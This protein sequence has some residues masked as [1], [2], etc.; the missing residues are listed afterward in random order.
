MAVCQDLM[1]KSS[2]G[3]GTGERGGSTTLRDIAATAGVGVATVSRVLNKSPLV[4]P[5]T[6]ERV[7]R[8]M[9]ELGYQ[10]RPPE[11]R[12]GRAKKRSRELGPQAVCIVL[13]G[14]HTLQWVTNCAPV[15]AYALNGA[16]STLN[17]HGINCLLRH[18][19]TPSKADS[20]RDLPVDGLL[21]LSDPA[22]SWPEE[23][24][25]YPM[26]K[27]LGVPGGFHCDT[28]TY[29]NDAVGRLAADYLL[30]RGV[31]HALVFGSSGG[32]HFWRRSL[33]FSFR[34]KEGGGSVSDLTHPD[35]IRVL[36]DANSANQELVRAGVEQLI[37]LSPR[38]SGMF[39]TSDVITPATYHELERRGISPMKD[40]HIVTCNNEKP[41][42]QSLYP[43][44][45]VIDIQA[46]LIGQQAV[47]RLLWR[48]ENPESPHMTLMLEPVLLNSE[49]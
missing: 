18:F 12:Q 20:I 33:S 25:S 19:A 37:R 39:V 26:V 31:K 41:Y 36:P 44:P 35:M 9:T 28:V 45:A 23:V 40:I 16:E 10:A 47:E 4:V 6:A 17:K 38:P 3:K 2:S 49:I 7:L 1:P 29:N 8:I 11:K 14:K 42:L 34:M 24:R 13:T 5:E 46:D 43:K 32:E 21:T 30:A 15:Y 27:M 22:W 48:M